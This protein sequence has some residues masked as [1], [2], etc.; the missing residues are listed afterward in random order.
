[1][2]NYL[3][4]FLFNSLF[5]VSLQHNHGNMKKKLIINNLNYF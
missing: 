3:I 4:L 5:L 1:M 2:R